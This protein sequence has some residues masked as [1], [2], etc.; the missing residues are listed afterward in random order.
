MS[1]HS[2]KLAVLAILS[3]MAGG[4]LTFPILYTNGVMRPTPYRTISHDWEERDGYLFVDIRLIK[5]GCTPLKVI[6]RGFYFGHVDSNDMPVVRLDGPFERLLKGEQVVRLRIGPMKKG[7]EEVEVWTRHDCDGT[8]VD[9]QLV[10]I[11]L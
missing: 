1:I 9:K 3:F 5:D 2:R 10:R 11:E 8:T 6:A 4:L 7:Y